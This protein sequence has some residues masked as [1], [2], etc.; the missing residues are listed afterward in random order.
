MRLIKLSA[1]QPG[2]KT[3]HFNPQGLTLIV[4]VSSGGEHEGNSNGVGKSL[5]LRLVHHCLGANGNKNFSEKLPEWIFRL[6]FEINGQLHAIE[7]SADSKIII[8]DNQSIKLRDLTNWLNES[9]VFDLT[10]ASNLPITFRSLIKRFA[11][12][13]KS[14]CIEPDSTAK[15]TPFDA[16]IRTLFLL[17][18][19]VSL[20]SRKHEFKKRIDALKSASQL[21]K[22]NPALH[23]MF[24]AGDDARIRANWLKDKIPE[25]KEQLGRMVVA[26]NYRD[27]EQEANRQT[28][29]LRGISQEIELLKFQ[30][31]GISELL[32]EHP[33]VSSQELLAL[34]KGLEGVFKAE[35]LKHFEAV[36]QFHSGLTESRKRRLLGD[37]TRINAEIE[38][39]QFE[40]KKLEEQR[41]KL[42]QSLIGKTAFEEYRAVANQL[43]QQEQELKALN[44]YLEFDVNV[45]KETLS[46]KETMLHDTHQAVTY[47]ENNPIAELETRYRTLTQPLYPNAASGITF[48]NNTGENMMRYTFKPRLEGSGSDGIKDARLLCFDWLVFMHGANHTMR[49]L[50]H[51]NRLFAHLDPGVRARWFSLVLTELKSTEKQYIATI[52]AENYDSMLT[53]LSEKE[54]AIL[55]S[56]GVKALEL[57]GN[58]PSDKL[59]GIQVD[60]Q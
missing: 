6:D 46:I 29:L 44:D 35:A 32:V 2:F 9:G 33:D 34:Y 59:L 36:E 19:D 57:R 8:L 7:R 42:L 60:L 49:F 28:L 20:V 18:L 53:W 22:I 12:L 16:L 15:E 30:V 45:N 40:Q 23:D 4:G 50:W 11:R 13:E 51:D 41:D 37:L 31:K 25:L 21:W 27:L 39:K 52:N 26:E 17:G 14:D 24:R 58:Q 47:L 5:A 3:I 38:T 48:E 10:T 56:P 1:N 54:R 43:A 55:E